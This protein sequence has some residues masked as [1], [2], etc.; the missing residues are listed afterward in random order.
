MLVTRSPD[1]HTVSLDLILR[2]TACDAPASFK[3]ESDPIRFF[4]VLGGGAPGVA[5]RLA[6]LGVGQ[7]GVPQP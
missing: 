3:Q 5:P 4:S 2:A 1:V 6:G 7:A